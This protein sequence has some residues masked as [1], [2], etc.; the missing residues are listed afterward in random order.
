MRLLLRNK[1]H[2]APIFGGEPKINR[3]LR[4]FRSYREKPRRH[5][6]V[7]HELSRPAGGGE[8]MGLYKFA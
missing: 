2:S 5:G 7:F 4:L 3:P 6:L 8:K 1:L